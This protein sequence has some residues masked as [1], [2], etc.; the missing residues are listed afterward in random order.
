MTMVVMIALDVSGDL[1]RHC[2]QLPDL[3]SR[4]AQPKALSTAPNAIDLAGPRAVAK[5]PQSGILQIRIYARPDEREMKSRRIVMEDRWFLIAVVALVLAL[6]AGE[7]AY[8]VYGPFSASAH[9]ID[10]FSSSNRAR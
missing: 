9:R 7:I 1:A 3:L 8:G 5:R 10:E 2:S 4:W 6:A